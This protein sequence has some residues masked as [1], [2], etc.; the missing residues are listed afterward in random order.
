[1]PSTGR[2]S[3]VAIGRN[4]GPRLAACFR[5]LEGAQLKEVVYVD[6]GSTDGSLAVAEAAGAS[7]VSLDMNLPFTAARARNA[8]F[9]KAMS[10]ENPP[11]MIQFIDAD[12][13]LAEGWLAKAEAFLD[14][15]P[16]F[17][18]VCGR[19][20]ERF[21]ECSHYNAL[22]D[23]EWNSI[24]GEA[25]L[26]GGDVL[27]HAAALAEVGGYRD[28]LICGEEPEVC[29]RLRARGGRMWRLDAKMTLHDANMQ[30]FSQ[31]WRRSVRGGYGYAKVALLHFHSPFGIWKRE[32]FRILLYGLGV[33]AVALAGSFVHPAALALLLF[34]PLQVLRIASREGPSRQQSWVYAFHLVIGKFAEFQ[35]LCKFGLDLLSGRRSK[36][37]EYKKAG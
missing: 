22:C 28:E 32:V 36:L 34:Y 5:S 6:S 25:F 14:G 2:I 10:A 27:I 4:E 37:I 3:V 17:T 12:C 1:M 9:A 8:G 24:P 15:H 33:P 11:A 35:G 16:E 13:A 18:A 23:R 20:R 30:Y 29:I 31:W 26:F 19:R 21:P 7:T